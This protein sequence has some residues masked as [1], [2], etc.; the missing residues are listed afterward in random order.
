MKESISVNFKE[1][2]NY[3]GLTAI[4]QIYNGLLDNTNKPNK[5]QIY[6]GLLDKLINLQ[7]LSIYIAIKVYYNF[8]QHLK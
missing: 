5:L 6:N 2:I 3:N 1:T 4:A 7:V 8:T